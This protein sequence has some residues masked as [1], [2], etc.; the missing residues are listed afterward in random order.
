MVNLD[1]S[2]GDGT[3]AHRSRRNEMR[4]DQ[5][6]E[7][8]ALRE[9]TSRWGWEQATECE[10]GKGW[11]FAPFPS[12]RV[13]SRVGKVAIR[14]VVR[15]ARLRSNRRAEAKQIV[16]TATSETNRIV[17]RDMEVLTVKVLNHR[18]T[19]GK[20]SSRC[21]GNAASGKPRRSGSD[22]FSTCATWGIDV[23]RA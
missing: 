1:V 22:A 20:H 14:I 5:K 13:R 9:G 18:R 2:R 8:R 23:G 17:L 7:G 19:A 3:T 11:R 21:Q 15:L 16:R 10:R 12:N 4:G 6:K